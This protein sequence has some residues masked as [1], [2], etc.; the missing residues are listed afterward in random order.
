MFNSSYGGIESDGMMNSFR[1]EPIATQNNEAA[2]ASVFKQNGYEKSG[3]KG[4]F[5]SSFLKNIETDD[6]ILIGIALLLLLD[7]DGDND[8][9]VFII[10]A[11]VLLS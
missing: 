2:E 3:K 4:L 11:L 1:Q 6:L 7:G 9:F 5:G 8:I 10:A